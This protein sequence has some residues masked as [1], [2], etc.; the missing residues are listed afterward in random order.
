MIDIHSHI[1]NNIDDGSRSIEE[2]IE[3]LRGLQE[4]GITDVVLTPHYVM[5]SSYQNS[6][7]TKKDLFE[8]LKEEVKKTDISINMYLGNEIYID[9]DISNM[10][11]KEALPINDSNYILLEFPM[12]GVYNNAY[13]IISGLIEK[14][15]KIILAHPERYL[16]V[17]N[18]ISILDEY[19][20]L[21]VLFQCNIGSLFGDYGKTCKKIIIKLLKKKYV[22]FIGTDVHS[23]NYNFKN[24]EKFK[25]KLSKIVDKNYLSDIL[26]NNAKKILN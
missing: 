10:V 17:K 8:K 4:N 19:K 11:K 22:D 5:D 6:I 21:G 1:L 24:I 12:N 25:K 7:E 23:K 20:E 13:G 16:N 18:D 2:S 26:E 15:Y 3:I 14:G 9:K